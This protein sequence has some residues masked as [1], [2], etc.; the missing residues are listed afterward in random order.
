M[1][2][3]TCPRA[4]DM[5]VGGAAV[6]VLSQATQQALR[7]TSNADPSS[8]LRDPAWQRCTTA[9]PSGRCALKAVAQP[10]GHNSAVNI[11]TY[12]LTHDA[13]APSS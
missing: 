4:A 11:T 13:A 1:S 3:A 2:D 6:Y 10:F 12:Y 5:C 9:S 7:S 8:V